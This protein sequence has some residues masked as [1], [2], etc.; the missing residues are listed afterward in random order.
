MNE[1]F[2]HILPETAG[3]FRQGL[4]RGALILPRCEG[5]GRMHYY[6]RHICPHCHGVDLVW[7][8]IDAIGRAFSVTT[9]H[10]GNTPVVLVYFHHAKEFLFLARIEGR[11]PSIGDMLRLVPRSETTPVVMCID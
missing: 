2:E 11:T 10:R 8:E 7:T 1:D 4:A 9:Y 3:P 5:C 6:P